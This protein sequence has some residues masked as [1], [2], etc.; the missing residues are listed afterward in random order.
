MIEI[1]NVVEFRDRND[2]L[3]VKDETDISKVIF[4]RE[5]Q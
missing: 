1:G 5:A 3:R 4:D 2:L